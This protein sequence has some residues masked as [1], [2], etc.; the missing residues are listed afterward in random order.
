MARTKQNQVP[1]EFQALYGPILQLKRLLQSNS[2]ELCAEQIL[3]GF[4][5]LHYATFIMTQFHKQHRSST[6]KDLIIREL[7]ELIMSGDSYKIQSDQLAKLFSFIDALGKELNTTHK[8][9]IYIAMYQAY[10]DAEI[11]RNFH[12]N[13]GI[14][15][16]VAFQYV[17]PETVA[18]MKQYHNASIKVLEELK[19]SPKINQQLIN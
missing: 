14:Y 6:T 2:L 3:E 18:E 1:T 11:Y 19:L 9:Y 7:I 8:P 5:M 13:L 4:I 12:S 15:D 16:F 10:L 17:K